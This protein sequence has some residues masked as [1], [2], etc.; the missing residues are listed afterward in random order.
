[1]A[2][3]KVHCHEPLAEGHLGVLEYRAYKRREAVF[4]M[5]TGKSATLAAFTM[6]VSAFG[7]YYV[8]CVTDAPPCF[9]DGLQADFLIVEVLCKFE[10]GFEVG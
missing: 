8:L 7:A 9:D 1:M 10:E 5:I 3:D 4:A 2:G 6:V